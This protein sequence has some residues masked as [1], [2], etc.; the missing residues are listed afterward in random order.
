MARRR[1]R[2]ETV[3]E[4]SRAI[5][6]AAALMVEI[7]VLAVVA[8]GAVDAVTAAGALVLVPV[9]YAFSYARRRR[10]SIATKAVLAV[11]LLV[12]LGAF[13]RAVEGARS[14]DDARQPLAALFLWVQV[15]HS[16]DVPRR[17]DLGFSVASG[18]MLMAEAGALSFGT[19]FLLY[20]VPWLGVSAVYL[21]LTLQPRPDETPRVS[22]VRRVD[23]SARRRRPLAVAG[24]VG[25][26]ATVAVAAM[27]A[28]FLAMPRLP[29]VNLALPPFRADDATVVPNFTGQVVNPGLAVGSDGVP[30]FAD[31]A[32]PGFSSSVDLRSRGR[33]SDEVVMRVRSP[34]PALWRGLAYDRYDGTRW[35]VS[36]DRVF[37]VVQEF[38]DTFRPT[39]EAPGAVPTQRVLATFYV[40]TDLP[41]VVFGAYRIGQVY[42]P[43]SQL[44]A[45]PY[46][47]VRAP[48]L[49][50]DGVVYSVMSDV[51]APTADLLRLSGR[52]PADPE[53]ARSLAPYL[54]LPATLPA[55]VTDLAARIAAGAPTAYDAV[56]AVQTWLRRNTT[57][58]LD[59][60]PDPPGVDAVDR[61]LFET[62]EGFC[63]HIASAMAVLLRA[64]GIPTRLVTGFG[65]GHRNPFTGYWEVRAS[66]A[67]AWVEVFY[68]GAGWISYDPTFGV[69]AADPGVA[70]RFIAPEVLGSIGRFFSASIP[71]PVREAARALGRA[72]ASAVRAWPVALALVAAA[73]VLATALR[74]RRAR[75]DHGRPPAGAARAFSELEGAMAA[76]GHPRAEHQTA[77]EFLRSSRPYLGADERADAELVVR[78]FEL[79]RFSGAPLQEDDVDRA[80]AAAARVSRPTG[81]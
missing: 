14:F 74:R 1:R 23:P 76:R 37:S 8:Q 51:P 5:R 52:V 9:G 79:D 6:I 25:G 10:P 61:F 41:N 15:L 38:D 22:E 49:L 78:L 44:S 77:R 17:R 24:A 30:E 19:E 12:A 47:S 16:F 21:Y 36:D 67:H 80:L 75:R 13:L 33:L 70:G 59:I 73:A 2:V 53:L 40:Q 26:W 62:R 43:A 46:G 18:L 48:I 11:A 45:D 58:N 42:F 39:V 72:L 31:L 65:P 32:Y 7:A 28:A 66:D 50:E 64:A 20:L 69:P 71:E 56:E 29:G 4:D 81:R 27:T 68:P 3:P 57:Y 35:T 54:E 55:R 60:P 34:Q 63:E